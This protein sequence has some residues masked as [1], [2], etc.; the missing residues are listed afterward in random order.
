[1][2][3]SVIFI[4]IPTWPFLFVCPFATTRYILYFGLVKEGYGFLLPCRREGEF[5]WIFYFHWTPIETTGTVNTSSI[6][7]VSRDKDWLIEKAIQGWHDGKADGNR[8][9][10]QS[11]PNSEPKFERNKTCTQQNFLGMKVL[12]PVLTGMPISARFWFFPSHDLVFVRAP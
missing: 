6:K 11:K 4:W 5:P 7:S 8:L 10:W 12:S 2:K 9:W 3:I 1:M